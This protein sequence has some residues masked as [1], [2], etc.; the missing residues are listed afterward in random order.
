MKL[1]KSKLLKNFSRINH[2]FTTKDSGVSKDSFASLNLAF[3]VGDLKLHVEKNHKKL[4]KKLKYKKNSLVHMKQIHSNKV[5]IVN[6]KDNFKNPPICDA[7]IT[8]ITNKPLMV[9]VADCAP[10][11]FYDKKNHTIA[12]AHSGR[13]GTFN[14]IVKSTIKKFKKKY[15][16]KP[17]NI[18]VSVGPH[19]NSCCYEVGKDIYKQAKKLNMN[20]A[21][22]KKNSRYYLNIKKIIKKQL[23]TCGI[24]KQ[25]IEISNVCTCCNNKEYFSY[26]ADNKT[27]RFC[28]VIYRKY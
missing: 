1:K 12:V 20:Y 7:L 26:R 15:N 21:I 17:K 8:N 18:I 16:S 13:A 27:G 19:I 9:M 3:H 5:H 10:I 2:S 6:S 11:L 24:K 4:A 25:N 28:G 14:N 23:L 22:K